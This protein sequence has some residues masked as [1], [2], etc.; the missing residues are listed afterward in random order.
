MLYGAGLIFAGPVTVRLDEIQWHLFAFGCILIPVAIHFF[1][2]TRNA[3]PDGA[4]VE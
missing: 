3:K 2:K 4:S 1:I